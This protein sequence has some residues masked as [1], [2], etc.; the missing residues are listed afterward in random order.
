LKKD[1]SASVVVED[2]QFE[3]QEAHIVLI[4]AEGQLISQTST[5]IGG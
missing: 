1:G 4:N 5:I 2:E 3:G